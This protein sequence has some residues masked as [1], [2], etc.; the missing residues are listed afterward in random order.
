MKKYHY[1]LSSTTYDAL[2]NVKSQRFTYVPVAERHS[3]LAWLAAVAILAM[4]TIAIVCFSVQT[5]PHTAVY[6]PA[7]TTSTP[8]GIV[9][10]VQP[11]QRSRP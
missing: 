2:G 6:S 11:N 8:G 9:N 7:L 10:H 1:V 5:P 3:V 4:V